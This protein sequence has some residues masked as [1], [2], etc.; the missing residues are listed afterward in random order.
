M[1]KLFVFFTDGIN[2][3]RDEDLT[4]YT[5]QIQGKGIT[6]IS[7]GVGND[8]DINEL[9]TI[10]AGSRQNVIR[11][12]EFEELKLIVDQLIPEKCKGKTR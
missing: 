10:A 12:G 8:T 2:T 7:V 9:T 5:R 3:D 1:E 4:Q 11:L 6:T